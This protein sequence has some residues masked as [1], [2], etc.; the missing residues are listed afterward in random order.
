M[1]AARWL[2]PAALTVAALTAAA[3]GG[4]A[5]TPR[6]PS[7]TLA[8]DDATWLGDVI[9]TTRDPTLILRPNLLARD[10]VYGPL[11]RKATRMAAA[12]SKALPFGRSALEALEQ[13][14]EVRIAVRGTRPLDAVIVVSGVPA[15]VDVE[16]LVDD[17]GARPWTDATRTPNGLLQLASREVDEAGAPASVLYV[18]GDR[19]W[20]CAVGR[21][22]ERVDE[23]L[24]RRGTRPRPPPLRPEE[25]EGLLAIHLRGEPL[26]RLRNLSRSGLRPLAEHLDEVDLVLGQGSEGT[27]LVRFSYDAPGSAEAASAHT[28]KLLAV[29]PKTISPN[30]QFLAQAGVKRAGRTVEVK[31]TLPRDLLVRLA[32]VDGA[33]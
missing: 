14:D 9:D 25:H 23:R 21:A 5:A 16:K 29:L 7:M 15:G 6:A 17:T 27:L 4:R 2:L 31:A 12:E 11:V 1:T 32:D 24:V 8:R 22:I 28:E 13:A 33:P 18:V 10:P 19:T 20:V 26:E 30:L 3:C